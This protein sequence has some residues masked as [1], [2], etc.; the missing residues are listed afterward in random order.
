MIDPKILKFLEKLDQKNPIDGP[1]AL[2]VCQDGSGEI[3]DCYDTRILQWDR[4]HEL[5][6][7]LVSYWKKKEYA[8][9]G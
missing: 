6:D 5:E 9:H 1:H 7:C 2:V 4:I 3:V 8:S